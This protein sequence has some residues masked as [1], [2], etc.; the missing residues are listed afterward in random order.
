ML[1]AR[2]VSLVLV[3]NGREADSDG[4]WGEGECWCFN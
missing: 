1:L 4:G 2:L 3:G